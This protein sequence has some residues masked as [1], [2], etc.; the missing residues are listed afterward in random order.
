MS[1]CV[2]VR[3]DQDGLA[4]AASLRL[5]DEADDALVFQR[6]IGL[7]DV[8]AL[9]RQLHHLVLIDQLPAG[10]SSIHSCFRV[11]D[12]HSCTTGQTRTESVLSRKPIE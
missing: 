10:H 3:V 5:A 6:R 2:L 1:A 9:V 4:G 8:S 12:T 11:F 7:A